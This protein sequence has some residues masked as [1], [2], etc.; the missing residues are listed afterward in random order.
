VTTAAA[1]PLPT[2]AGERCLLREFQASDAAAIQRHADDEAVWR[3][4]FDGFPRPY[5]IE[6]AKAWCSGG[7][8]NPAMGLVWCIDVDRVAIGCIGLRPEAGWL[9]CNAEVGYWIGRVYWRRGIT[10][11]ALTLVTRW[12][13]TAMPELTRLYAPIYATN[14]ASQRLAERCGYTLEARMPQSAIKAGRVIDR[15]QYA[16]YRRDAK[17][18]A[19]PLHWRRLTTTN[20]S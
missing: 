11:E 18:E 20:P 2:L 10:S 9:R 12:A 13:W 6:H 3:N 19:R 14:E 7:S 5:T 16:A 15:V 8:R 1:T 17:P 4:L